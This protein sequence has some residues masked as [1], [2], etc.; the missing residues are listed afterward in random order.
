MFSKHLIKI[1]IGFAGMILLGLFGLFLTDQFGSSAGQS[2]TN[3]G[4]VQ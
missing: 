2:S 3:A 4:I 1:V